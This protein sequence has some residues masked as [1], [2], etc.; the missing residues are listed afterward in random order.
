MQLRHRRLTRALATLGA[1]FHISSAAQLRQASPTAGDHAASASDAAKAFAEKTSSRLRLLGAATQQVLVTPGVE[2]K[3]L[4]NRT[5][6]KVS[7]QLQESASIL[8]KWGAHYAQ[9][10]DASDMAASLAER[11]AAFEVQDLKQQ[12][13]DAI[14]ADQQ[15]KLEEPRKLEELKKRVQSMRSQVEFLLAEKAHQKPGSQKSGAA[16]IADVWPHPPRNASRQELGL[17]MHG[18]KIQVNERDASREE[19]DHLIKLEA[20]LST[21]EDQLKVAEET[22]SKAHSENVD[23]H[24]ETKELVH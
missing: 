9:N 19:E 17:F 22:V 23:A 18:T 24:R 11:G 1:F 4:F 3:P 8:E 10:A 21:L 14:E 13:R 6:H 7:A 12:L 15:A 20:R 2:E 16:L 5:L